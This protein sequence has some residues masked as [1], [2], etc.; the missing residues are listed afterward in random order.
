MPI[1]FEKIL[2]TRGP[3]LSAKNIFLKNPIDINVIPNLRFWLLITN[4]L[5]LCVFS[6]S[7][8]FSLSCGKKL[9][10]LNIGPATRGG[11]NATKNVYSL[12]VFDG[13][14]LPR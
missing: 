9:L 12:R 3:M 8:T 6:L 1:G 7:R 10:A 13:C 5:S 14:K 2:V 4:N 11:K